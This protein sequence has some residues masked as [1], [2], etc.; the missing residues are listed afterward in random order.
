ME[1]LD[2]TGIEKSP[3]IF[4]CNECGKVFK[5]KYSLRDHEVEKHGRSARYSCFV[6]ERGFYSRH[7]MISHVVVH[8]ETRSSKTKGQEL[9]KEL[10]LEL[11]KKSKVMFDG[12]EVSASFVC[13]HCGKIF[14]HEKSKKRHEITHSD[15]NKHTKIM[16]KVENRS[17]STKSQPDSN[18]LKCI[19]DCTKTFSTR[20]DLDKHMIAGDHNGQ[21]FFVCSKCPKK[22]GSTREMRNHESRAHDDK[23]DKQDEEINVIPTEL[24]FTCSKCT[25]TFESTSEMRKHVVAAHVQNPDIK[26]QSKSKSQGDQRY[27]EILMTKG[28]HPDV[29]A[30]NV[31]PESIHNNSSFTSSNLEIKPTRMKSVLEDAK[32]E[33]NQESRLD[34]KSNLE[35]AKNYENH[36][37]GLDF[38]CK[39]CG[40]DLPSSASL[41]IHEQI[42]EEQNIHICI[43]GNECDSKFS[44]KK[45]LSAHMLLK[46]GLENTAAVRTRPTCKIC[47][48]SWNTVH[49]LK[50]H[51][52]RHSTEKTF[53]C[54]ECGKFLKTERSLVTHSLLHTEI[55]NIECD[56]CELM[57][58]TRSAMINHKMR[59][60]N[61][62]SSEKLCPTCG[63]KCGS[64]A[65][66]RRHTIRHTGQ[67]PYK[68]K[69]CEKGFFDNQVRRI[70]ERIHQD[71]FEF[72]C[73]HCEKQFHQSHQ[74]VA[75]TKRHN[76]VRNSSI[77]LIRNNFELLSGE[78]SHLL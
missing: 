28:I 14:Q 71:T 72:Q 66:L 34:L 25:K 48:K 45:R 9:P 38:K 11:S 75:H 30:E 70:H 74:L 56:H 62:G 33:E 78:G 39:E 18:N 65:S 27:K 10:L 16:A 55:K 1:I 41:K 76:G 69:T 17:D 52:V 61:D 51:M 12:V 3:Q 4:T 42:H 37:S 58:Y 5:S 54:V 50:G 77:F 59:N 35:F 21:F 15:D 49:G 19:L 31:K 24:L 67:R 68:C 32:S 64:K 2:Q 23:G 73:N 60:H 36:E 40:S 7:M 22:F 46:H 63:E 47:N 57:F 13:N 53:V 26:E 44:T 8:D 20:E 43:A 6:C 29:Y